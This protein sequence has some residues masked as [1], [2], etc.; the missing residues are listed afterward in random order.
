MEITK[1]NFCETLSLVK[2]SINEA[3][4]IAIDTEF[5]GYNS[6]L[7]EQCHEYNTTEQRY[8]K[9]KAVIKKFVAF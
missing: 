9:M 3:D 4:F 7:E 8:K 5:S 1:D 6:C 2:D